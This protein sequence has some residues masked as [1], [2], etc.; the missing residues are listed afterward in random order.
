MVNTAAD[1]AV[2]GPGQLNL[3]QAVNLAN[4]LTG[5]DTITFDSTVFATAQTITLAQGQ[6]TLSNRTGVAT[7]A[8]PAGGVT[9]SGN[10]A[11]RVFQVDGGVTASISGLTIAGGP[12]HWL[13]RRNLQQ[14][15][16]PDALRLHVDR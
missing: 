1:G 2:S 16:H 12:Y 14:L 15:R 3:R 10:N 13:R 4:V 7:I 9:V 8:G 6:I 5:A 11:S